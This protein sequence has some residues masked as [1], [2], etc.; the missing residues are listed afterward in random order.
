MFTVSPMLPLPLAVKPVAPP[1]WVAVY[2]SL[3][4][5]A[6]MRSVTL[7]PVMLLG[8]LLVT[9]MVYVVDPPGVAVAT[10][11][12]LVIDRS[13]ITAAG[14]MVSVSVALLLPGLVSV[15]PAGA[16]TVAVFER[17][18]LAPALMLALTV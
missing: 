4:M 18:P 1:L 11:S 7:A 12:V 15:T 2:V 6:G 9:T 8:P 16:D 14:V 3:A 13:A 10:P 5:A 17:L